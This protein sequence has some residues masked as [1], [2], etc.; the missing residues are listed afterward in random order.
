MENTAAVDAFAALAHERRLAL[1]RLLVRAGKDG[2]AAGDIA[3]A[4]RVPASTLSHHLSQLEHS[5]LIGS[6][7][8]SRHIY[9]AVRVE[10]FRSLLDYIVNDCCDG[11]P[12]LC[13]LTVPRNA[14]T[15]Q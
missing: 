4:L 12:D 11:S 10:A 13:G 1:F 7:R 5:G 3:G 6:H 15:C 9:Y 14:E 8:E 2:M